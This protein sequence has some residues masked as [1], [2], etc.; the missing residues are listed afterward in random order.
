M[1]AIEKN[2]DMLSTPKEFDEFESVL[3]NVAYE[4]ITSLEET[5]DEV[6]TIYLTFRNLLQE[7]IRAKFPIHNFDNF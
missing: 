3:D 4:L 2:N 6:M 5:D 7:K 1:I